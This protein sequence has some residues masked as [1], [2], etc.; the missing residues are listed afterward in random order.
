MPDNASAQITGG[1]FR[2]P[3]ANFWISARRRGSDWQVATSAGDEWWFSVWRADPRAS[4]YSAL[5][6]ACVRSGGVLFNPSYVT[7]SRE[8]P[9]A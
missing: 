5:S 6:S 4:L 7:E 3:S 9:A 8:A 2:L 1:T